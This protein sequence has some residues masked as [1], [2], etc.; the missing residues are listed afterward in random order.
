MDISN[1]NHSG[2]TFHNWQLSHTTL[3]NDAEYDKLFHVIELD[4]LILQ[5]HKLYD[6]TE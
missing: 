1:K 5:I 2:H 6:I 4:N 3:I